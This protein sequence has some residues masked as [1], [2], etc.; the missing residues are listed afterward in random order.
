MPTDAEP[1]PTPSP[2]GATQN[3]PFIESQ[4]R[5]ERGASYACNLGSRLDEAAEGVQVG[6]DDSDGD[7]EGAEEEL[8][9]D[10]D[11]VEQVEVD[12]GPG[13][14]D[15]QTIQI[16][17]D[18]EDCLMS[19][20]KQQPGTE[21]APSDAAQPNQPGGGLQQ[22]A[23]ASKTPEALPQTQHPVPVV[24]GDGEKDSLGC[25]DSN[26]SKDQEKES[27]AKPTEEKH[28]STQADNPKETQPRVEDEE[29]RIAKEEEDKIL[30]DDEASRRKEATARGTFKA[31]TWDFQ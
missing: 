14:Q 6:E 30:S 1:Q 8:P 22:H 31:Q 18:E 25:L 29:A 11:I 20:S 4:W 9:T 13:Y 2:V 10:D 21:D 26:L 24:S 27:Q 3:S 28:G 5:L 23:T 19:P 16:L 12:M 7:E 15:N 17:S